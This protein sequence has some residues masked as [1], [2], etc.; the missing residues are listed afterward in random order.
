MAHKILVVDDEAHIRTLLEL[1]LKKF[2][3][4]VRQAVNARGCLDAVA[5][6][7]EIKAVVLDNRMPGDRG[8]DIIE[9][10]RGISPSLKII[11]IT[12]SI[13]STHSDVR[14]DA[15]LRKPV[16]LNLLVKTIN[17]LLGQS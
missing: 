13:S 4:D 8:I 11:L 7:N 2:G 5:S 9:K 16:D 6:D 14:L 15:F 1:F 12:G 17:D 10:L 3:F